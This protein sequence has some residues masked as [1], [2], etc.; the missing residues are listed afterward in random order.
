MKGKLSI[1]EMT[2]VGMCAALMGIFSQLSIPMPFTAVP[3][4]LQTFGAVVIAVIL[5]HKLGTLSMIIWTLIGA[6]G[7]PVFAGFS[8]GMGAIL[9]PTG[10]YIIGFIFMAFII[11]YGAS[12]KNKMVLFIATYIG[13]AVQY[14]LGVVQ[15]K[16]VLELGWHEALVAGVYPFVV[17][18]LIVVTIAVFAALAVKKILKGVV[19]TH[20]KA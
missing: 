7:I 20:A 18:D 10:G 2:L 19:M 17:K 14:A 1:K 4:T 12:K 9:G 6:I 15:M 16:I 11:G 3:L 13:Q 5:E 8:A